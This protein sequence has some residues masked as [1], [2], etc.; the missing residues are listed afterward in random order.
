MSLLGGF[1]VIRC[2]L[3]FV[4]GRWGGKEEER[5]WRVA[6]AVLLG[7]FLALQRNF[8]GSNTSGIME[9]CA[10]QGLFELMCVN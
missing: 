3:G 9:I 5:Q 7:S 1:T 8:N 2:Y 10:R 6:S 4:V